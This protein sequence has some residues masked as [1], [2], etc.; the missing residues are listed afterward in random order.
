MREKLITAM[1]MAIAKVRRLPRKQVQ[2]FH[3]NDSDGLSSGA[4]L[5]RAFARAGF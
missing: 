4:I 5:T 1:E 3:H 2:L